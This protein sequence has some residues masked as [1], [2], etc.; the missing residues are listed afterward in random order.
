MLMEPSHSPGARAPAVISMMRGSPGASAPSANV[1]S[2]HGHPSTFTDTDMLPVR[3]RLRSTTR[4]RLASPGSSVPQSSAGAANSV[5]RGSS[6][7]SASKRMTCASRAGGMV[8]HVTRRVASA[9]GP[10]SAARFTCS[11]LRSALFS[12]RALAMRSISARRC[13]SLRVS[14]LVTLSSPSRV[15]THA[16]SSGH[17]DRCSGLSYARMAH[18]TRNCTNSGKLSWS[19]RLCGALAL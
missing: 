14:A 10:P 8:P 16:R 12:L 1:A 18:C 3:L 13:R 9:A 5:Q 17:N 4:K 2:T 11:H 7:A 6:G 19:S 15:S